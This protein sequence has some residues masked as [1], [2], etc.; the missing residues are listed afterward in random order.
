M[1]RRPGVMQAVG[2]PVAVQ[3]RGGHAPHRPL[4]RIGGHRAKFGQ[5]PARRVQHQG[6]LVDPPPPGILPRHRPLLQPQ[7]L[8]V[9]FQPAQAPLLRPPQQPQP[10]G[11]LVSLPGRGRQRVVG[12]RQP[13]PGALELPAAQQPALER[14]DLLSG[15]LLV[16]EG[17]LAGLLSVGGALGRKAQLPGAVRRALRRS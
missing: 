9:G 17:L 12:Q 5:Q 6:A 4:L 14:G 3:L 10:L 7:L 16:L 1:L 13:V 11:R 15:L 2:A 8:I